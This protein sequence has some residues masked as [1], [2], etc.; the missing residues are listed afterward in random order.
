VNAGRWAQH[1]EKTR[2]LDQAR[3]LAS[4]TKLDSVPISQLFKRPDFNAINL[5]FDLLSRVPITI[6]QL[7]E[8]DFKYQGYAARQSDQNRQL[9]RRRQ[10]V[11]PN[12]LD[13][14]EIP[15]LRSET[16]QKLATAR[17]CS[18]GQAARISGITPTDV[19]IISIWLSKNHLYKPSA[20]DMATNSE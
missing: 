6:W 4:Q 19:A 3:L 12:W 16:R 11:I 8:T 1:R 17:P 20:V 18:L 13:Y 5:P 10:E 9:E 15:G 14:D 2:L 7:V